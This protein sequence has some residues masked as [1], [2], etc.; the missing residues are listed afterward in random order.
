MVNEDLYQTVIEAPN[1][2]YAFC[3]ARNK[4]EKYYHSNGVHLTAI[5]SITSKGSYVK[6]YVEINETELLDMFNDPIFDL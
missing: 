2:A 6:P 5:G 1:E 3:M 4:A